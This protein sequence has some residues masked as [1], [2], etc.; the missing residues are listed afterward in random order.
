MT[1]KQIFELKTVS[2]SHLH[3]ILKTLLAKVCFDASLMCLSGFFAFRAT[4]N[5]LC[6]GTQ[7]CGL[8]SRI[9]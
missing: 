8:L 9:Q 2:C 1:L 6:C 3:D 5:D 4:L 7:H